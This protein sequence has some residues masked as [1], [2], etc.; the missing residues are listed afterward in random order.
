L[1]VIDY[2]GPYRNYNRE[3]FARINL[4]IESENRLKQHA[5]YNYTNKYANLKTEMGS[6]YVR[7]LLSRQADPTAAADDALTTT[8]KEL[9]ST[10]FP[11]KEFL[12]PQPT[13][14]GRR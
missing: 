10:F 13:S 3:R 8:L 14:D 11:G 2:H 5:L 6:A 7:H 4:T 9:F 12:G 1:G